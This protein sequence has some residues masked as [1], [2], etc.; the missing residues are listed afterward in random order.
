[1][2]APLEEALDLAEH[3]DLDL[4][5]LDE[6]LHELAKIDPESSRVVELSFFAG[7]RQDEIAEILGVSKM[8]VRRRW[9]AARIWL[10]RE[11]KRNS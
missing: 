2:V 9:T 4:L 1:M 3:R 8:T 11:L 5:A 7:L 6:A 10:F